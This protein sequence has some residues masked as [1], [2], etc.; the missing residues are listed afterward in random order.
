[1]LFKL[2][3]FATAFGSAAFLMKHFILEPRKELALLQSNTSTHS[4]EQESQIRILG[5]YLETHPQSLIQA[6]SPQSKKNS[7]EGP[8]PLSQPFTEGFFNS[9]E[10][11]GIKERF[12]ALEPSHAME[13]GRDLNDLIQRL[14]NTH[15]DEKYRIL[16]LGFWLEQTYSPQV[17]QDSFLSEANQFYLSED[18]RVRAYARQALSAY[19]DLEPNQETR[20]LKRKAF[21]STHG[22]AE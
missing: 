2:F 1:M 22:I 7:N 19:L 20:Y 21:L 6:D 16:S 13:L 14:D 8:N 15:L 10:S 3:A 11:E 12:Q 17:L 18:A 5:A 4:N 9:L